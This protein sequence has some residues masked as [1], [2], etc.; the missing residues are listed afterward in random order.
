MKLLIS[1]LTLVF[2]TNLAIVFLASTATAASAKSEINVLGFQAWKTSRID[3]AKAAVER[4]TDQ[5]KEAA[6]PSPKSARKNKHD[7]SSRLQLASKTSRSDQRLQQAQINLEMAQE[8]TVNDYFVLYLSQF[9]QK[10]A[11]IEAAKKLS[12]EESADLMM[13]YQKRLSSGEND[14]GSNAALGA[15]FAGTSS[16]K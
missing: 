13:S 11:F 12:A 1:C 2:S 15:T 9:K 8:L 16:L 7:V 4:L 3:D 14:L 10:E 6:T 5:D